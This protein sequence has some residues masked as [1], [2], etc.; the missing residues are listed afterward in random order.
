MLA[1]MGR[2]ASDSFEGRRRNGRKS[3]LRPYYVRPCFAEMQ[4]IAP[5]HTQRTMARRL[6]DHFNP[7]QGA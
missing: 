5:D 3:R 4:K 2:S 7:E 1:E 6:N